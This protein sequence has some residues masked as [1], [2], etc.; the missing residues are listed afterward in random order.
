MIY[1][2]IY[3]LHAREITMDKFDLQS[4]RVG[5]KETPMKGSTITLECEAANCFSPAEVQIEVK[6]G[7]AGSISLSL[8]NDCVCKF[9][10]EQQ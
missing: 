10:D 9:R 1:I 4:T 3:I 6:V 5:K 2:G 8:C 7:H